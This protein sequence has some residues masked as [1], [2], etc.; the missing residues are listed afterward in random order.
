[1][2]AR[3]PRIF[4]RLDEFAS[5]VFLCDHETQHIVSGQQAYAGVMRPSRIEINP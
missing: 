5:A 2:Q 4:L 3:D 1:M